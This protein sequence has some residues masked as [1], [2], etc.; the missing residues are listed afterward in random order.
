MPVVNV[1]KLLD[2]LRNEL[3]KYRNF[4]WTPRPAL[5]DTSKGRI[6]STIATLK[7]ALPQ[8]NAVWDSMITE[9]GK[10]NIEDIEGHLLNLEGLFRSIPAVSV[11]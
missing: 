5:A 6:L 3:V 10:E 7:K 9:L 8:H 1:G 11:A 2:D 4:M